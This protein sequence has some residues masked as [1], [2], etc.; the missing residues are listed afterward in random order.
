MAAVRGGPVTGA[1][2]Q[3]QASS[4]LSP[5]VPR[6]VVDWLRHTPDLTYREVD[7]SLAFLDISGFTRLTERLARRGQEGAEEMSDI[8]NSTFSRLLDVGYQD[9]AGL[10]KWGGDAVLL[11]F[12]G[13]SHASRAARASFR[14]REEMRAV[15]RLNTS[16]GSIVLRM[17]AGLHSGTF[18]F[19]LVGDPAKHRELL[20]A[21]PAASITAEM[22]GSAGAG[23]IAMSAATADLLPTTSVGR[24]NRTSFLLRAAPDIEAVG[25]P[26]AKSVEGLD[27]TQVLPSGIREHLTEQP[28]DAEHRTISVGF[29]QFSGTDELHNASGSAALAEALHEVIVNVQD[30]ADRYG[31]TFFETDINRDGGKVMLTAGAPT[32]HGHDED[33]MLRAA[34]QIVESAG[35]LPLRV[36][37]NRGGVFSGDFGPPFRRTYSVKGDAVN[38]AAR[39]MARAEVGQLLATNDVVERR[40]TD[41]SLTPLAPFLVKGK[42]HPV[43]AY[44]VGAVNVRDDQGDTDLLLIGRDNEMSTL[45]DQV[46]HAVAGTGSLTTVTGDRGSGRTRIAA[47]LIRAADSATVIA[48]TCDEYDTA[49]PYVTMRRLFRRALGVDPLAEDTDVLQRLEEVA[50]DNLKPWLP[51]IAVVL[52]VEVPSTPEVDELEDEFRKPRMELATLELLERLLPE[53]AVLVIDDVHYLDEASRSLLE[54]IVDRARAQCPWAVVVTTPTESSDAA[55]DAD[56]VVELRALTG[57][58]AAALVAAETADHPLTPGVVATIV[59]RSAG[60]PLFLRSLVMSARAGSDIESLP[61]TIEGLVTVEIDR[62]PPTHRRILRYAAVLGTTV[63]Q[64]LLARMLD[65]HW[66][67]PSSSRFDP[68]RSFLAT[69]RRG[70]L[71][72]RTALIRDV[73]YQGLPFRRRRS[74]HE[75]AGAALLDQVATGREPPVE[76][77]AR[78]FHLADRAA[79]AWQYSRLAAERAHRQFAHAEVVRFLRW[80]VQAAPRL[81][82]PATDRADVVELLGD[83]QFLLGLSADARSSYLRAAREFAGNPV[84]AAAIHLKLA[85]LDQR[86]GQLSQ[87]LRRLSRGLTL[88]SDIDEPRANAVRAELMTRYAIGRFQQ[89]RYREAKRWGD[90]AVAT[91]EHSDDR[92]VLAN[93]HNALEAITLWS[94]LA[95]DVNHGEIALALYE[96]LADLAGQGH[97]L[98]NLAIRAIFEGRWDATQPLL[99][100]A[101]DLFEQIGDVASLAAALY[102]QADVLVRQGR[103]ADAEPLLDRALRIARSVDDDETAALVL[104][105]WGKSRSRAGRFDEAR[106][107][108]SEAMTMLDELGEPQELLDARAALAECDLLQGRPLEALDGAEGA[109][110]SRADENASVLPTLYRIRG[111]A[112]LMTDDVDAARDSF[113]AGLALQ[114]PAARHE[115]AFL[116]VGRAEVARR[117]GDPDAATLRDAGDE[118]MKEL[119]VVAPPIPADVVAR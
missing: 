82:V 54:G 68:L 33:R 119:G 56:T 36:G 86:V 76:R 109:L 115:M 12:D 11:L 74:L 105:D 16:A 39:V 27:L 90:R 94:G 14:M 45:R 17:S 83:A 70:Q 67:D 51:L 103:S 116:T 26:P 53:P 63:D 41:F 78:H 5:Y 34:R 84:R 49:T 1:P 7:G 99:S 6:L 114:S 77:L 20:V 3:A 107:L 46:A 42:R 81:D 15:G 113:E 64:D 100:R 91:A 58:D 25:V 50:A 52:G 43:E 111:F 118:A 102:N 117:H 55:P 104:R 18:H 97:S 112:Y 85:R 95:S 8:L 30:A 108:L 88:V 44:V 57:Q 23:D 48:T 9:G 4:Q 72:F 10:V 65:E 92:E 19:F 37:V 29:V 93:A 61:E 21:G 89:G 59:S 98:N 66:I 24:G 47:E 75:Q 60:N 80:A 28:G 13:P 31:V 62:L 101:A 87:S 106:S 73:A 71:Q 38:L 40:R 35:R 79:E 110:K 96:D 32:S 2:S 22:E 69:G